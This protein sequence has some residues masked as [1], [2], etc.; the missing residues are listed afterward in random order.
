MAQETLALLY[1]AKT[2]HESVSALAIQ[3]ASDYP[4]GDILLVGVLKGAFMFLAGLVR[5]LRV[6]VFVDFVQLSSYGT[7]TTSSGNVKI[8]KDIQTPLGGKN[9]IIVEDIIDTGITLAFLKDELRKRNPRSLKVCTLL[10]KQFRRLARID[11]DYVGILMD[12][13]HFV[14]GYGLDVAERYRNLPEVYRVES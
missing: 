1:S 2:I 5:A 9:V 6:P 14:V 10:D 3:I 11:A 4:E 13:D 7:S 12:Q 8:L